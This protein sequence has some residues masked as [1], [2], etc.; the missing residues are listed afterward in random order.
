[1]PARLGGPSWLVAPAPLSQP[2]EARRRRWFERAE[3]WGQELLSARGSRGSEGTQITRCEVVSLY[4]RR[5]TGRSPWIQEN[6]LN[7]LSL[8]PRPRLWSWTFVAG[9][10]RSSWMV[11]TRA[12]RASGLGRGGVPAALNSRSRLG[13]HMGAIKIRGRHVHLPAFVDRSYL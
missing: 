8:A 10:L 4:R 3:A 9:W 7:P 13:S 6:P 12:E 2:P 1:M 11:P 5:S